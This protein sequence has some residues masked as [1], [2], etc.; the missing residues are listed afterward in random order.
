[1]QTVF[2]L[3]RSQRFQALQRFYMFSLVIDRIENR[4]LQRALSNSDDDDHPTPE[5]EI[6]SVMEQAD[7]E[8]LNEEE[9]EM[10]RSVFELG[11]T[12]AREIMTPRVNLE[13]IKDDLTI[14]DCL[15]II[16]ESR[17]TRFPVYHEKL[18]DIRG[19]IHVKDIL[20]QI[21]EGNE[22]QPISSIVKKIE[23]IPETMSISLLLKDM[24]R[25]HA[26]MVLV[27][28]EYGGTSGI[29][30]MEDIIEELVGEISDEYDETDS[31]FQERPDGSYF[32]D[33]KMLV[34]DLNEKLDLDIRNTTN[35]TLSADTFS[36]HLDTSQT[37]AEN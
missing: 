26:Q 14:K 23:F 13:G 12:V 10:I 35:L 22:N 2:Q 7:L 24:Q 28:D 8:E 1:M 34:A 5:D 17:H 3:I 11:E 21:A 18:D 16:R 32:I 9:R 27:V 20:R 4:L 37:L 29:V 25:K 6:L 33:A 30:C 15:S 31:E 36:S 19:T